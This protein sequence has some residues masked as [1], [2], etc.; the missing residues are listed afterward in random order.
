[1]IESRH[2]TILAIDGGG[3]RCRLAVQCGEAI[4]SV[5]TGSA[6]IST[7][8]EGAVR[9]VLEGLTALTAKTALDSKALAELPAFVGLAGV[10]GPEIAERLRDALPFKS[11]R[12]EDDRPAALRGALGTRD[13]VIAHC[14]TGSF[15]GAQSRGRMTFSGGWGPVLGDEASA[16]WVGRAALKSTLETV[17]G[18][19]ATSSLS[20]AL[21]EQFGD[22]SGIVRFAGIARPAEFGAIAP[23]VTAQAAAGDAMANFVLSAGASEIARSLTLIGWTAGQV[24]CLT[25]GIGPH[26]KPYLPAPMQAAVVAADGEP[27]SGALSLARDLEKE[28]RT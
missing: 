13:G 26:F 25:G 16:Q 4:T 24:I 8:F 21:L 20:Q 15:F 5:E 17:D 28:I 14:G 19:R 7:D 18:Q 27:L 1:M 11:M 23:M 3:T 22:A 2:N 10:T 9:Q 12:V 6:N